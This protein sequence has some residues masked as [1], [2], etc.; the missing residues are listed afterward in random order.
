MLTLHQQQDSGNCYKVRLLLSH[1]KIPFTTTEIN[2]LDGSTQKPEFLKLNP[3]G[4]VPLIVFDDGKILAESNAMLLYFSRDSEWLPDDAWTQAKIHEWLFFEQYSHEPAIAVR[5]TFLVYKERQNYASP[6]R[7]QRLLQQGNAALAVME[8]RIKDADYLAADRPTV[9]DLS[10][11]AYTHLATQAGYDLQQFP[12]VTQWLNRIA[13]L[14]GHV[15]IN[16]R[17]TK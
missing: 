1:L 4:K 16:W 14:P 10:L 3:N 8:N 2:S 9:A 11:Y 13:N 7:M 6:K 15:D 5:R 12:A 17:P